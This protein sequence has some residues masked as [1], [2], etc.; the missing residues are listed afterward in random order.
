[1]VVAGHR[2]KVGSEI[3]RALE[4]EPGME[5][6]GG[7]GSGDDLAALLGAARPAAMVDFTRPGVGLANALAAV[8]AGVAPVVGTTG[9]SDGDV[10]R[11]EAACR[12][13]GVGGIVAPNFAIGAVLMM[14]LAEIAAPFFDA[15]DIIE[16]HGVGKRDAPSGTALGTAR[17]MARARGSQ[18]FR[19]APEPEATLEGARGGARDGIGVHSLRLPGLLADQEVIFGLPG[20]TLSVIHRTTGRQAFTPG[21]MLAIRRVTA[22]PDFHRGLDELLGL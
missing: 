15:V 20:Q 6:A 7:A 5:Y 22:G 14:R 9:F 1:M 21:V 3:V 10:D 2:G 13:R 19:R 8:E 12:E 4:D 16:A 17:R 11:L 18:G